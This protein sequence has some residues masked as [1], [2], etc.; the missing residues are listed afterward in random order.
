MPPGH[1]AATWGVATLLK[2]NNPGLA[3]LDYRLLAAATLLPDIIDKPL[4][5][6]IFTEAHTSQL[7]AHS[8]L[9]NAVLLVCALLWWRK[10]LPYVL[11]FNAHVLA[12]R[13]WNH[14]ESFWWPLFGW[15]TF[16]TYKPMNTPETMLN[17]YLDI[18]IHYPQVWV[19]E[20]VALLFLGWF[21]YRHQLYRWPMLKH[22]VL[23]GH[24]NIVS[25]KSL[26][27]QHFAP[28]NRSTSASRRGSESRTS[29]L[30]ES[31]E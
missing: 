15:S 20:I 27:K 31:K 12:D 4:A 1:V 24:V 5:I 17:V 8:F 14:T 25:E 28:D 3:R 13:M 10:P 21:M 30:F 22:F 2:K 23:T 26:H 7:I 6:F 19:I 18:V 29:F 9:F 11:A 16:W